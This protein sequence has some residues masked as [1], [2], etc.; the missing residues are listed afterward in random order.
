VNRYREV[1]APENTDGVWDGGVPM[2]PGV[3]NAIP[4]F[5]SSQ[6]LTLRVLAAYSQSWT[7]SPK[8]SVNGV[9]TCLDE[10]AYAT[11]INL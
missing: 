3:P 11:V 2:V 9:L 10:A 4:S 6:V 7:T 5:Q 1:P 8:R